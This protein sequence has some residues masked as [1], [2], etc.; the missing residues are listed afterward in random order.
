MRIAEPPPPSPLVIG[1][2]WYHDE[3]MTADPDADVQPGD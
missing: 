2:A 3:A 1:K